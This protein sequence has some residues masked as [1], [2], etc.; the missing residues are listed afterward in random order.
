M[1]TPE[2]EELAGRIDAVAKAVLHLSAALEMRGVIDGPQ[3]SGMWRNAAR[4]A[5]PTRPLL[6]SQRILAE[7]ADL[8]DEARRA[9]QS[10]SP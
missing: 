1:N 10:R 2:Y 9:R 6:A 4:L 7:L 8:L 5:R 3:L